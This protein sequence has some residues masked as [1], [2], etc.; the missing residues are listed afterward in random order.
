MSWFSNASACPG[1][2][3]TG[4]PKRTCANKKIWRARPLAAA[5]VLG[6]LL[7]G[8]STDIYRDR[9]ETVAL[10]ADD[11]VSANKV[12]HMIDPWPAASGNRNIPGEGH[13]VAAA[14]ERYRTGKVIKPVG[15]GTSSSGY[16]A[17]APA[18]AAPT[19]P[20]GTP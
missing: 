15:T 6:G 7:A 2:V 14:I 18:P 17:A 11:A 13:R 12:T 4:F 10:G 5:L 16:S 1:K 19:G 9:R 8:C 20:A 3:D